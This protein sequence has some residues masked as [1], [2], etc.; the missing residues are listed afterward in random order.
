MAAKFNVD[1]I[2]AGKAA[3]PDLSA[4]DMVV[5][6]TSGPRS[7]WQNVKDVL[8]VAGWATSV[9]ASAGAL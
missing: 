2:R 4:G 8:P 6:D 9:A 5:V 7:A 1:D 3:D